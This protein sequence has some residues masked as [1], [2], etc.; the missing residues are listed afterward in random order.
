[1]EVSII[2][3]TV[4]LENIKSFSLRWRLDMFTR[5][6]T[7]YIPLIIC[8]EAWRQVNI[9]SLPQ[10][11][12]Y[13]VCCLAV[14]QLYSEQKAVY[15]LCVCVCVCVCVLSSCLSVVQWTEGCLYCVCVLSSCLSAVQWTEGCP[16]Q[17]SRWSQ[18]I[19]RDWLL[20]SHLS[21]LIVYLT[22]YTWSPKFC[23][24]T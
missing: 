3:S 14:C 2:T 6:D 20:I 17:A 12:S 9:T 23:T 11:L 7:V 19:V 4:L 18:E 8:L 24:M 15:I 5:L 1:M 10:S 16:S 22:I 13:C 21:S